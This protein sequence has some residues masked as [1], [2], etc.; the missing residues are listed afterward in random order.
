MTIY[1]L[2]EDLE[3]GTFVVAARRTIDRAIGASGIVKR[4]RLG[5]FFSGLMDGIGLAGGALLEVGRVI[6]NIGFRISFYGVIVWGAAQVVRYLTAPLT[7][8]VATEVASKV[9]A[10]S[11]A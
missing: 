6:A 2:F 1:E 9:I 11:P 5:A 8:A 3:I 10:G 4:S 7:R